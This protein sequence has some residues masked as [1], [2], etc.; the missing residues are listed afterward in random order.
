MAIV[1]GPADYYQHGSWNF[2]CDQCGKKLKAGE[3]LKQWNN[4]MVGPECF[5]FRNPLDFAKGIPDNP[6]PPWTRPTPPPIWLA[7]SDPEDEQSQ[8]GSLLVNAQLV[9]GP[10]LG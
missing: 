4:L 7:G 2:R 5:E 6:T 8:S 10:L 9:G 1:T 3:G